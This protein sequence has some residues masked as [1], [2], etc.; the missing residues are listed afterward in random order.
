MFFN[1]HD[2]LITRFSND[3]GSNG[4]SYSLGRSFISFNK[5][6][7]DELSIISSFKFSKL[8]K[9]EYSKDP[10]RLNFSNELGNKLI[11]M[12]DMLYT[13]NFSNNIS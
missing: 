2:P 11:E 5:G 12:F 9:E 4:S 1:L 13:V 7:P 3:F 6:F 8:V 10:Y